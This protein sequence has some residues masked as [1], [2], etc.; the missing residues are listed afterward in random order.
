MVYYGYARV[1]TEGQNDTSIEVQLEYLRLQAESLGMEFRGAFEKKSG[2]SLEAREVLTQL[3]AKM[4]DGDILGV[5]DNS[6]LGRDTAENIGIIKLLYP[7]GVKVQISSKILNPENPE[8]EL[9]FSIQSSISTFQRK[10]QLLKARA[11]INLKKRNGDWV[12]RGDLL[13]YDILKTGKKIK[14]VINEEEAAIVRFIFEE[15]A[16][17]RSVNSIAEELS[18]RGKLWYAASI[19]RFLFNPIYMGYYF[20]ETIPVK[21]RNRMI[22]DEIEAKLI[23]SNHYPVIIDPELWWKVN[24]SYRV[25]K[26]SHARQFEYRF[27]YYE[28]SSIIRCGYCGKGYVH[29]I[30][31]SWKANSI[32]S[33]YTCNIHTKAC[34]ARVF[35]LHEKTIEE[36][37]RSTFCDAML[38]P[39]ETKI[40]FQHQLEE[41]S[42]STEE[43]KKEIKQLQ[44]KLKDVVKR[45]ERIIDAVEQ[46][47]LD[48]SAVK[49]RITAV[50]LERKT[51]EERIHQLEMIDSEKRENLYYLIAM[52]SMSE[53]QKFIDGDAPYRRKKYLELL[54]S[55]KLYSDKLIV[56]YKN[57]KVYVIRLVKNRGRRIQREFPGKMMFEGKYKM[58]FV[59]DTNI[60]DFNKLVRSE[61]INLAKTKIVQL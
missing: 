14:I 20:S 59:I 27:A 19:R 45:K 48:L 5:Y 18:K 9:F 51:I 36:V 38:D 60:D 54:E 49:D 56:R 40:F 35:T 1:S 34:G 41:L 23:R 26:R 58:D 4:Q 46:G 47:V 11:G 57:S 43:A 22:R 32:V 28:L 17:G 31:K 44:A 16:K 24:Q 53:I 50:D 42:K 37:M 21:A 13:G 7:K 10:T 6:R 25:M 52:S 3:L 55:C 8:D 61:T 39:T 33:S 15:Y 29:S 12:L 30:H 2:K